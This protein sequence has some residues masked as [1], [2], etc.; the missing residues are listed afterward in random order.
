MIIFLPTQNG[1]GTIAKAINGVFAQSDPDWHLVV[2]ENG[3][4]DDTVDIVRSYDDPRIELRSVQQSLGIVGNWQRGA[5]YLREFCAQHDLVTFLGDDDW[6]YPGFVAQ[7][8]ALADG[9]QKATL[10]QT[11]FDLVDGEGS[12]IRPCRPIP[13]R[14]SGMDLAAALCWNLRDSF[15]TGYA[16]RA[17]D[18]LTVGGIPDLPLL[19]SSDHLLFVR[20][21]MLG[22]KRTAPEAHCAYRYH[23]GSTSGGLSAKKLNAALEALDGL[24]A[25]FEGM[26][27]FLATERGRDALAALLARELSSYNLAAVG[28]VLTPAN[29][30]R[31]ARLNA[32]F[33]TVRR[34]LT[35][36]IWADPEGGAFDRVTRPLRTAARTLSVWRA[37]RR[38]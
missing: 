13:E 14:E 29:R 38:T 4:T 9:D 27:E 1:A 34:G 25:A 11:G 20:L 37:T 22:H 21:A 3:S 23:S 15:G 12:L 30:D 19:L 10:F 6:F 33:G 35:I 18:Y 24:V 32:V 16:F 7:M 17:R 28:R 5:A 8:R 36:A 26:D 31:R 2:L